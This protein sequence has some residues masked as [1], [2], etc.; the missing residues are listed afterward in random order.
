MCFKR[1]QACL[2]V[3]TPNYPCAIG[4]ADGEKGAQRNDE[5]PR[6][7]LITALAKN[8]QKETTKT[9]A[10]MIGNAKQA[11]RCYAPMIG[12]ATNQPHPMAD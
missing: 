1:K 10:P 8:M 4:R 11:R 7:T 9:V 3:N 12:N 5:N 6:S 2:H